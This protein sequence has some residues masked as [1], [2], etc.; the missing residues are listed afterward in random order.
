MK[1]AGY[2]P[3]FAANNADKLLKN[4]NVKK[5]IAEINEKITK[6]NIATVE[7][8]QMFWTSILYDEQQETKDRLRASELLAKCKG[9]FNTESW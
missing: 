3:K 2:S 1:K 9:L 4:T 7:E 6:T 8:I 5:Y